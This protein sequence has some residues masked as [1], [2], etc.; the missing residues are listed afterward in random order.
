MQSSSDTVCLDE[1]PPPEI[2]MRLQETS[3]NSW[4]RFDRYDVVVCA[5]L[6]LLGLMQFILSRRGSDF[7]G[8]LTYFELSR[9]IARGTGYGFNY[10]PETMLPPGF[11][12]LMAALAKIVGYGHAALVRTMGVFT[13]L[14]LIFA[15]LVLRTRQNRT[16][17]AAICLLL[18][19]SPVFFEFS[20]RVVSSDMPYFF[21]SMILIWA[22]VRLD[23]AELSRRAQLCWWL[24]CLV[25]LLGTVL[26]RSTGIALLAALAAWL[27]VSLMKDRAAAKRRILIFLP[28]VILGGAVQ[29]AWMGWAIKH[30]VSQWPIHGYQ[31]NYVA[32]LGI[33]N[34]NNPESGLAAWKDVAMRPI[35]NGDDR[36]TELWTL[37]VRKTVAP[38]W[39]SPTT[40]LPFALVVLGLG[41]SFWEDGGI[42]EWYFLGYE[43]M[44]LF[45]PWSFEV[46]FL[47]PVAPLGCLY[48]WRGGALL[49]RLAKTKLREVA[50]AGVMVAALGILGSAVWG[51]HI[52][53]PHARFCIAIWGLLAVASAILFAIGSGGVEKLS[54]TF[55]NAMPQKWESVSLARTLASAAFIGL[56]VA[57]IGMQLR[58]GRDNLHFR[59][60]NDDLYPDIEAAQWIQANTE[61]SAVVM[62]RKDDLVYHYGQRRVI[63]FP[64]SSNPDLIMT[65][66]RRYHVRY[67]VV[68]D[69]NERYWTPMVG[70]C[71]VVLFKAYPNAFHLVHQTPKESV[72]EVSG[73]GSL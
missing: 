14:G 36:A 64:P 21:F 5:S 67:V 55:R 10:K 1:V 22:L 35:Y 54:A 32:Q 8:D 45:W 25:L 72:Y 39:Y 65:G 20:T 23:S 19:S 34:G 51:R 40:L 60:E 2:K 66:I 33:K 49:V 28:L 63:W 4:N 42:L 16:V 59:V 17:A 18:A 58:I 50:A 27:A 41:T 48:M 44:Y 24:L 56:L 61:P 73:N 71:F 70:E 30:Q 15:Y 37:I 68:A 9:S 46:R 3:G 7:V 69:D 26:I 52:E 13:T 47:L 29:V 11:P 12:Y 62:A 31:E 57:G 53:H 43:A 6:V 38:A